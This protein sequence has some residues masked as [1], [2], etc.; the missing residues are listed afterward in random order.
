MNKTTSLVA[1]SALLSCNQVFAETETI[2]NETEHLQTIT[3]VRCWYRTDYSRDSAA[4]D[5]EWARIPDGRYFTIEGY[6]WGNM[7]YTDTTQQEI[8]DQ[9]STT[10]GMAN[11]NADV[12][13]FAASFPWSLN[14]TIWSTDSAVE[15]DKIN[16]IVSFGDSLSDTGNVFG[17]SQ[18][19]FPDRSSWFLG[20]FSNGF[21]WTEYLAKAKN[22]PVYNWAVGGSGGQSQ[23]FLLSGINDQIKSYLQYM[24]ETKNYNP[25]NTLF[26]LEFGLNDFMQFGRSAADVKDDFAEALVSLINSGAKNFLLITLPDVTNAPKFQYSSHAEVEFIRSKI[27]DMN[28]FIQEQV[29][30]YT[31]LGYNMTLFDTYELF[32]RVISNPTPYGFDNA[33]ESCLSLSSFSLSEYFYRHSLR[34]ECIRIGSD[35]FVFWDSLH[36]TTAVHQ[37]V[38]EEILASGELESN[39]SF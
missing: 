6:W 11:S 15:S 8:R 30:Y 9:C 35:K 33:T 12:T 34:E 26:T 10:L 37:Y 18:F 27:L 29:N 3:N 22:L 14:N 4:T 38:A 7:F 1:L 23:F 31:G 21:V 36:P 24:D 16:K 19:R 25:S 39:H 17:A 2:V 32:E 13:Y 28:T 5:Y 20:H